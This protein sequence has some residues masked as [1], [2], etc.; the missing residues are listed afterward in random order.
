M[1]AHTILWDWKLCQPV[2]THDADKVEVNC[3]LMGLGNG[4]LSFQHQAI[5]WTSHGLL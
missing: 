4:L 2:P 3:V 1:V 5:T